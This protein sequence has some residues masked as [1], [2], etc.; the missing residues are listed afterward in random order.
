MVVSSFDSPVQDRHCQTGGLQWRTNK[1]IREIEHVMCEEL[2]EQFVQSEENTAK[3]SLDC[4]LQLPHEIRKRQR[5]TTS[6]SAQ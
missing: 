3:G 1:E 5:Q 6:R 2:R 4:I